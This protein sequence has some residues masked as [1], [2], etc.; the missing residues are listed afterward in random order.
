[1][2]TNRAKH[3]VFDS[4]DDEVTNKL[5]DEQTASRK[6]KLFEDSES[7]PEDSQAFTSKEKA[8]IEHD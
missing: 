2:N 7:E 5:Q 1:M 3:I 4:D 6:H 8:D